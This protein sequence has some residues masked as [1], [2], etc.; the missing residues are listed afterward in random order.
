MAT[1]PHARTPQ[2]ILDEVERVLT[3]KPAG[4]APAQIEFIIAQRLGPA[5]PS[6]LHVETI[7]EDLVSAGRGEWVTSSRSAWRV[8][9][10]GLDE[11]APTLPAATAE[12]QSPEGSPLAEVGY[13][14]NFP[15][16]QID[17]HYD[18]RAVISRVG[19]T[20][21]A[22]ALQAKNEIHDSEVVRETRIERNLGGGR[23]GVTDTYL[24]VG[25][26][27]VRHYD[28]VAT[29][30]RAQQAQRDSSGPQREVA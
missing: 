10:F 4:M 27:T 12:F 20:R 30:V 26:G 14:N 5:W 24:R 13:V 18:G 11:V 16:R 17:V 2:V 15:Y 9:L 21:N 25:Q 19:L 29:Q 1:V 3:L 23:W 7:L 28:I 8:R 6:G 22:T